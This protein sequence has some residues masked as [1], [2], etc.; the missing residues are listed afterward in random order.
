MELNLK[1]YIAVAA[2]ALTLILPVRPSTYA[3]GDIAVPQVSASDNDS[4]QTFSTIKEA[5]PYIRSQ[6]RNRE[7]IITFTLP[8]SLY[9]GDFNSIFTEIFDILLTETGKSYEG[10]YIRFGIHKINFGFS[11]SGNYMNFKLTMNYFTDG[12]QEK[13]VDQKISEIIDSLD[14]GGC[15]DYEKLCKIYEYVINS[16]E[17]DYDNTINLESHSAYGALFNKKAVC[18]GYAQ[19]L[20]RLSREAGI[21]CRIIASSDHAWNIARINNTYYYLDPTWDEYLTDIQ[22]CRYFLKGT[23]DFDEYTADLNGASS[24]HEPSA[25]KTLLHPGYTS[26]DFL[27]TYPISEYAYNP[28]NVSKSGYILGDVTED[29]IITGSDATLAL[30]AYTQLS[31][32]EDHGLSDTQFSA[33]EVTGDGIITGSDA[34]IILAYYTLISSGYTFT[35]EEYL[36]TLR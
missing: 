17:Y 33:A 26:E 28:E 10:D 13:L 29:G 14:I 2:A 25:E 27:T 16:A 6:I 30:M 1:K 19:L 8:Q 21:P 12:E 7:E 32:F 34:T 3:A 31:S 5:V 15:T 18:Q 11:F 20:Y 4:S 24:S 22:Q 36:A 23:N 35:M 9:D